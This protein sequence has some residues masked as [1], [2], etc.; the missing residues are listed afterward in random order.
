MPSTKNILPLKKGFPIISLKKKSNPWQ[1]LLWPGLS[2]TLGESYP[3]R[4]EH[5]SRPKAACRSVCV[6]GLELPCGQTATECPI[7]D[8]QVALAGGVG[9]NN[10]LLSTVSHLLP[11]WENWSYPI[12]TLYHIPH[13]QMLHE[14]HIPNTFDLEIRATPVSVLRVML[15]YMDYSQLE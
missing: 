2:P 1:I 15:Y 10:D 8:D 4:G 7:Q 12:L 11:R 14:I 5:S 9:S 3:V 6:S 13:Q